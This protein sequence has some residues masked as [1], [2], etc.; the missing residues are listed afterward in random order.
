MLLIIEKVALLKSAEIFAETPDYVLASVAA[1]VEEI[2]L[3]PGETFIHEGE[4]ADAMY[5]VVDGEVQVHSRGTPIITLGPGKSVGE[6]A[7]LDPEPRSASVKSVA[8]TLVLRIEKE[9]LD[10]VMAD[11]PE[12]AQAVIVALCRRVREQGRTIATLGR[13]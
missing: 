4:L 1:I 12:I 7:V 13:A 9:A 11:R 6:L 8:D 10:E 2:H 3:A 5:L